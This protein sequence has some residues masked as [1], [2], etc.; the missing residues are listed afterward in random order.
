ML[1]APSIFVCSAVLSTV[2]RVSIRSH[3]FALPRLLAPLTTNMVIGN[4]A[5]VYPRFAVSS[6]DR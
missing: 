4:G 2:A 5:D 3:Q 1:Q 6:R